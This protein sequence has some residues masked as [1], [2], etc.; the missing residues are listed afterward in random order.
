MK[1]SGKME[2]KAQVYFKMSHH[3]SQGKILNNHD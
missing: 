1:E 3:D 2:A